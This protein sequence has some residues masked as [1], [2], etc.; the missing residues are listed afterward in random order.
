MHKMLSLALD[1][2]DRKSRTTGDIP[3][4]GNL[5]FIVNM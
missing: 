1:F 2:C 3:M 4:E 5:I